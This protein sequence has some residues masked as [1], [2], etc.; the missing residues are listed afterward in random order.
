M[1]AA[2]IARGGGPVS[3]AS[4]PLAP[5]AA[6]ER[7]A[8]LDILRAIALFGVFLVNVEFFA[9]PI[10]TSGFGIEPGL[11]GVNH[12]LAWIEYVLVTGKSWTLFAM[13]FGMGFAVMLERAG[14]AQRGFVAPYLRRTAALLAFGLAHV[15]LVWAGDILH[16]YAI[17]ACVLLAILCGR[18]WWLL[19]PVPAFAAALLIIGGKGYLGGVIG[20][21]LFACAAA[22]I[23][24]SDVGRLWKAGA[25]L[26]ASVSCVILAMTVPALFAAPTPERQAAAAERY[27][28][29]QAGIAHAVRVNAEGSYFDNLQLRMGFLLDGLPDETRLLA[30]AIGM[31]LIGVWFVRS[32]V[33]RD[34]RAHRALLA[35]IAAIGIPA[36]IALALGSAAISTGFDSQRRAISTVAAQLMSLASL[37]LSV[38]YACA[39]LWLIQVGARVAWL[40]PVGRMALT[41]YLMQSL[42]GTLLFYGYG[43]GL[44][45]RIDRIG[46]LLF[47]IGVF[48]L[49]IALSHWWL[50]RFHFGPAEWLWRAATYRVWPPMRRNAGTTLGGR[51]ASPA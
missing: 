7:I 21:V 46:Q 25:M 1:A 9:R 50:R 48:G 4:R 17:A 47:V 40:A 8:A 20:F 44:S 16:S 37:P 31:F 24:R 49:Q 43:A 45:G 36:G 42:I 23:R 13:L 3:A 19:L 41:N 11:S 14:Q 22:W 27:A 10:E 34:L 2:R 18:P 6:G 51:S 5:T 26:Y 32:G 15:A 29:L 35:R 33:V 12:A 30:V 28:E 39:V 38:G